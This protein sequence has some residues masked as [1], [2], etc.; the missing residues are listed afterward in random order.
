MSNVSE[1]CV[2]QL[3]GKTDAQPPHSAMM[4]ERNNLHPCSSSVLTEQLDA[5]DM[6]VRSIES[7][8]QLRCLESGDDLVGTPNREM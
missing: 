4:K 5:G 3:H 7:T 2:E 8:S 1:P 6:D